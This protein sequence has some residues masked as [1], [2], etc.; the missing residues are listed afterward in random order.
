MTLSGRGEMLTIFIGETDRHGRQ[1]LYTEIVSRARQVGLA[2]A[3]VLRGAEG[4]GATALVHRS[5]AFGLSEDLPVV[6][7]IVDEPERIEAFM[8]VVDELVTEGLVVREG[9]EVLVY[10]GERR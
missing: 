4:F 8:P 2:G 10:R 7:V 1:P 5:H 9:L 6:V 3:T